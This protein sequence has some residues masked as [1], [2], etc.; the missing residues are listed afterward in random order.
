MTLSEQATER[1]F[2]RLDDREGRI[3]VERSIELEKRVRNQTPAPG[4]QR[5]LLGFMTGV[6]NGDPDYD[7]LVPDYADYVRRELPVLQRILREFGAVKSASFKRV[8]PNGQDVYS[9]VFETGR[10]DL[11]VLLAPDGRIHQTMFNR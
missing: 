10:R 3:A 6:M 8:L 7:Q 11:A 9:I 1:R 4:G 5:A 2:T